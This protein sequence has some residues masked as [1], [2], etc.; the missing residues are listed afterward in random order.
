MF[1]LD[2]KDP[3]FSGWINEIENQEED[4]DVDL[5]DNEEQKI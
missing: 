4:E 1:D 2:L 5:E 3:A